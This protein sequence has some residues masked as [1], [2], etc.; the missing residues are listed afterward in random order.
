ML[1]KLLP[2]PYVSAVVI[3]CLFLADPSAAQDQSLGGFE[4]YASSFSNDFIGDGHDRWRSA[5]YQ[6]SLFYG[7]AGSNVADRLEVRARAEIVS[8]WT[9]A[10][11][12]GVD[13][14]Y[15]TAM[16]IG[17]YGHRQ[18]GGLQTSAGAEV[19]HV[20]SDTP[21]ADLQAAAHSSL[22][23][24]N[25]FELGGE[26][27]EVAE[28][29]VVFGFSTEIAYQLMLGDNA[30]IR[31]FV[32]LSG[33]AEQVGT[34]GADFL[35]GDI[36]SQ[37]IWARD[38]TTG[39]LTSPYADQAEG[40]SFIA[41]WDTSMVESSYLI[42]DASSAVLLPERSRVRAGVQFNGPM[43]DIFFGQAWLSEEFEGQVEG[44]QVGMLSISF[45]F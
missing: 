31:P 26:E 23:L 2:N 19:L 39:R 17:L 44:Q 40:I 4:G 38:V 24:E 12:P 14:P 10:K 1:K 15:V 18:F 45:I 41:G 3:A 32:L 33:G 42:S 25:S 13:R 7:L 5:S 30:A 16:G 29:E 27:Q 21:L 22:D 35:I 9:R 20:G 6:G 34:V 37:D 43:G 11:Q 28:S 8:P 36:A